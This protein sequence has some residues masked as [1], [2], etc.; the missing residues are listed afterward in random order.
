[1]KALATMHFKAPL[2]RSC[3]VNKSDKDRILVLGTLLDVNKY[4]MPQFQVS[5]QIAQGRDQVGGFLNLRNA[6]MNCGPY[7]LNIFLFVISY[8][9]LLLSFLFEQ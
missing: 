8:G 1:M 2:E 5:A 4:I 6:S 9:K 7:Y 3:W